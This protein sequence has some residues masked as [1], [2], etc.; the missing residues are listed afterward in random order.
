MRKN[1]G[2]LCTVCQLTKRA[3]FASVSLIMKLDFIIIMLLLSLFSHLFCLCRYLMAAQSQGPAVSA[4]PRLNINDRFGC[5]TFQ[6]GT[7]Q[8]Q[9]STP[10]FNPGLFNPKIQPQ[11]SIPRFNPKI[12][13]PDFLTPSFNPGLFNSR[14]FNHEIISQPI[15]FST[16]MTR[17]IDI[18][19]SHSNQLTI[20]LK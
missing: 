19:L 7:F 2:L 10:S 3:Q 6:P 14:L 12:Q 15:T 9:D 4:I 17:V 13:P 1:S 8:P 20:A 11:D 5:K 16:K 18:L